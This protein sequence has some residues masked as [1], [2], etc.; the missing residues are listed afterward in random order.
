MKTL[1]T[2]FLFTLVLLGV[3]C[4]DSVKNTVTYMANV[5]VYM[6]KD[7]F[8]VTTKIGTARQ[9][10]NPG[11]ICLYGDYLFINEVNEG[12]HVIDNSNPSSPRIVSFIEIIGNVDLAAK[13][14][15]LYADNLVDLLLFDI[16]NPSA[17]SLKS[18]KEGVFE[19]VLPA[20]NNDYPVSTIDTE[21]KVVVGW[22]QKEITEKVEY[23]TYYPCPTCYYFNSDVS[24]WK[25]NSVQPG[26]TIVG[27]N[28]SMSRFAIADNYLY[29]IH[30]QNHLGSNQRYS[31]D[32]I[33]PSYSF[34]ELN[35]FDLGNDRVEK[36]H[37]LTVSNAVETLFAYNDHLFL[38][39]S[40]G[41]QIYSI[42]TP[43]EPTFVSDTWHF[44]GC[45]PVVVSG[46][47][48]YLTVRSTN[49]C[50]QNDNI[51]QVIDISTIT[52]PKV[53]A[54]FPL[55]EPYGL[56]VD[57]NKLFVCD[58]GL[59]VFDA[60]DPLKVGSKLLFSTTEFAGFDLIPSNNLL[61]VIGADGLY[62]YG[63]S[64]D[65]QLHRLSVISVSQ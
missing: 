61:F 33:P 8:K 12:I 30:I 20:P 57:D 36:I 13:D 53:V 25:S 14:G 58:N 34:G 51:L 26:T 2:F 4:S 17:P 32:P 23:Y 22:E 11:K 3:S 41:M 49:T 7:E 10:K 48:A 1:L 42:S 27:V 63:Y 46:D 6:S 44:W 35:T 43:S 9:L 21:G 56:G 37:S 60:S 55:Q 24:T 38:G 45:D 19:G 62:Q 5:P 65:N 15:I 16:S 64:S 54:Q 29:T 28:G 31:S 50:G 59:K 18:R 52:Q 39:F 40:N 47:Y